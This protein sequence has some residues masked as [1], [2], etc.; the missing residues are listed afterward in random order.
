M[1]I[2]TIILIFGALIC[3]AKLLE[4]LAVDH[5]GAKVAFKHLGPRTDT[6]YMTRAELFMSSRVFLVWGILVS[7]VWM[8]TVYLVDLVDK[9]D[10]LEHPAAIA[11]NFALFLLSASGYLG[12]FWLLV[13]GLFRRADYDPVMVHQKDMEAHE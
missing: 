12:A 2:W 10:I 8:T 7:V 6:R 11:L 1:T 13:R 9:K 5:T 4:R 3:V